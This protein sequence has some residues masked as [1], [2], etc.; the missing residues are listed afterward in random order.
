MW[1]KVSVSTSSYPNSL[2]RC[3]QPGLGSLFRGKLGLRVVVSST[4]EGTHQPVG[5]ESSSFGLVSFQNNSPSQISGS[6][7]RQYYRSSLSWNIR[8]LLFCGVS[9]AQALVSCELFCRSLFVLL[10]FSFL[11]LH[12]QSYFDFQLL[13]TSLISLNFSRNNSNYI[14]IV[15]TRIPLVKESNYNSCKINKVYKWFVWNWIEIFAIKEYV[16]ANFV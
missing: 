6:G 12:C 1:W 4:T 15:E 3:F 7:N 8:F 2:H 14:F 13:I 10:S 9:V 16:N 11:S 5:D